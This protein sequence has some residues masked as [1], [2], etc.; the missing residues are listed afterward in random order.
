MKQ[1]VVD[2]LS[3]ELGAQVGGGEI[4]RLVEVPKDATH[5]D[6]AFPCF[7][8]AK[9]LKKNPKLIAEEL[10]ARPCIAPQAPRRSAS[11]CSP[12]RSSTG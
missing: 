12:V 1:L 10:A 6:Y 4:E 9:V 8:L 7:G 2:V 5:G 11:G 3:R